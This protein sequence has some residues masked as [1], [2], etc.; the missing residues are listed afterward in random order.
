MPGSHWN[1]RLWTLLSSSVK[2]SCN[3][4]AAFSPAVVADK[5]SNWFRSKILARYH[6]NYHPLRWSRLPTY[7]SLCVHFSLLHNP[8]MWSSPFC[9]QTF[10]FPLSSFSSMFWGALYHFI[11]SIETFF[12]DYN[13]LQTPVQLFTVI[14]TKEGIGVILCRDHRQLQLFW[15]VY[16]ILQLTALKLLKNVLWRASLA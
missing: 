15:P 5:M 11:D 8:Q 16:K 1:R 3:S 10:F 4:N 6:T 14:L 7:C 13:A 12:M 9:L 2:L